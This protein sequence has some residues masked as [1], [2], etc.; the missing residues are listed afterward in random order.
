MRKT[1]TVKHLYICRSD[2]SNPY[3]NL[4]AEQLLFSSCPKDAL[5]LY[6]WQNDRT[7]V[8]GKNQNPLSECN[9]EKMQK[10]GIT[11][12]RRESGGGAVYH[13]KGNLNFTFICHSGDD[14]EEIIARNLK[15]IA[16]ACESVG[17]EASPTGRNDVTAGGKKF[18]G[19]A[20]LHKEGKTCHH[21]TILIKSDFE[22]LKD[23]LTPSDIKLSAKGVKSVRSR[24]INLASL[25]PSLTPKKM[26]DLLIRSTEEVF[27]VAPQKIPFPEREKT[28]PLEKKFKSDGYLFGKSAPYEIEFHDKFPWGEVRLLFSVEK[29]KIATAKMYTD[30][31]DCTL[32]KKFSL[33]V[34]DCAFNKEEIKSRLS[35]YI[36]EPYVSDISKMIQ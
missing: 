5:I 8:I 35:S 15:I 27:G 19:N 25:V 34:T 13:D 24:V 30:S 33:A 18:S 26:Q 2:E 22:A 14:K 6:L 4:A 10:D 20:F 28:A 7:V 32:A 1:E 23:Y 16:D 36:Q 12:A 29:G 17:I 31:M 9:L 21:G 3:R 11:L